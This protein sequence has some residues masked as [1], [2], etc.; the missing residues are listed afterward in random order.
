MSVRLEGVTAVVAE[1]AVAGIAVGESVVDSWG[2]AIVHGGAFCRWR[3][4]EGESGRSR[5]SVVCCR[6]RIPGTGGDGGDLSPLSAG[7]KDPSRYD[8]SVESWVR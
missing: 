5:E 4:A 1:G 3:G 7:A 6:R 8:P 2:L